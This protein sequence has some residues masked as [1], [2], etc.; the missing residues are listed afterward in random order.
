MK[1]DYLSN[2]CPGRVRKRESFGKQ[3]LSPLRGTVKQ[4]IS[5][6]RGAVKQELS[7]SSGTVKQELS[8]LHGTSKQE[9]SPSNGTVKQEISSPLPYLSLPPAFLQNECESGEQAV[10]DVTELKL[11]ISDTIDEAERRSR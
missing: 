1:E 8:P 11:Q 2:D 10:R 6:L 5:P 3:E 4:E 9:L 7:P